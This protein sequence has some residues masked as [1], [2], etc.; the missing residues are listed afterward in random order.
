MAVLEITIMVPM[1]HV[2]ADNFRKADYIDQIEMVTD[3]IRMQGWTR[4]WALEFH[5]NDS[6]KRPNLWRM[7]GLVDDC[8]DLHK[9][10][11]CNRES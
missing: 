11:G 6:T 5:L 4:D 9:W 10:C 7:L 8:D 3:Y 1:E 2:D